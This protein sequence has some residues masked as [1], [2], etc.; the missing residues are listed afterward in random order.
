[1]S[2]TSIP[3]ILATLGVVRAGDNPA[4][5]G[6]DRAFATGANDALRRAYQT[7]GSLIYTFSR[8]TVGPDRAEEVT[9]DVFVNAWRARE[10]YDPAKGPLVAWLIGIAKYRTIDSIRAERRHSDRR[11][12]EAEHHGAVDD[13]VSS[14]ADRLLVADALLTLPE[15]ARTVITLAFFEG[16]THREIAARTNTPLGTVKSDIRRGLASIK[17]HLRSTDD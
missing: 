4:V 3:S 2:P 5:D 15:R 13:H 12:E 8:R 14:V 6:L 11:A 10:R 9:Q 17:Q 7:H 1:M 16:L